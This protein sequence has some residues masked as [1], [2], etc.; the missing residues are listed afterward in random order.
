MEN[1]VEEGRLGKVA[2][3]LN[4][5]DAELVEDLLLN[6][7]RDGGGLAERKDVWKF[8]N[9]HMV[10]AVHHRNTSTST[11]RYYDLLPGARLQIHQAA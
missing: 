5:G 8:T 7:C 1:L 10:V 11:Q 3:I 9:G 6:L 2:K 4:S